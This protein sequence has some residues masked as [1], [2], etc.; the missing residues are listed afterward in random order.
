M[1]ARKVNSQKNYEFQGTSR[2]S[3]GHSCPNRAEEERARYVQGHVG[4]PST[5]AFSARF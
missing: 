4:A 3:Q 1:L 2:G 5:V